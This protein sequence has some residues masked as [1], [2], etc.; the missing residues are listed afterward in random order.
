M[1]RIEYVHDSVEYR[2]YSAVALEFVE[3]W[4]NGFVSLPVTRHPDMPEHYSVAIPSTD[5]D[6][7]FVMHVKV[8]RRV[9]IDGVDASVFDMVCIRP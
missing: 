3:L 7:P 5:A 6:D 1:Y 2:E 4:V 8:R 9:W